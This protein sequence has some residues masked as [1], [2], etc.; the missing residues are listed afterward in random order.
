MGLSPVIQEKLEQQPALANAPPGATF[1]LAGCAAG[2]TSA[3]LTQPMDTIKTRLQA[4][5]DVEARQAVL[6]P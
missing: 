4:F 1:V 5:L 3:L 6:S 2:L